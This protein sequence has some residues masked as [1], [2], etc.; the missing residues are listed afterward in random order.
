MHHIAGCEEC[1]EA[2]GEQKMKRKQG[3]FDGFYYKTGLPSVPGDTSED[4]A[5]SMESYVH[6]LRK[7]VF[8][9][10]EEQGD[11]TC[12]EAEVCL[13][14]R[15]QTASARIR[16]LVLGGFIEDTGGRRKTRSGRRARVY[17]LR[18]K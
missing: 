4:A 11:A 9:F 1:V 8:D 7:K 13:S 15:H 10:I 17:A 14:L 12:D 5:A 2:C 6:G 16:E 18:K 3:V